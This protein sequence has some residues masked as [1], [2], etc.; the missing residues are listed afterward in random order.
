M[1]EGKGRTAGRNML[2]N[3]KDCRTEGRKEGEGIKRAV[4][5]QERM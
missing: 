1:K 4:S 5:I 3:R 2:R